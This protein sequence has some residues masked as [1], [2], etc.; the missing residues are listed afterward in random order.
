MISQ[1]DIT[2]LMPSRSQPFVF[3]CDDLISH[4]TSNIGEIETPFSYLPAWR[5]TIALEF[6]N[7]SKTSYQ[8]ELDP[9]PESGTCLTF[10]YLSQQ[11]S[12][13]KTW[14]LALNMI[15]PPLLKQAEIQ[16][17]DPAYSRAPIHREVMYTN[18][19]NSFLLPQDIAQNEN[20][21]IACK[22]SSFVPLIFSHN[23][24]RTQLSLEH[25]HPPASSALYGNRFKAQS[26]IKH[27]WMSN[28]AIGKG[29]K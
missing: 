16:F 8:G 19:I 2:E 10:N 25:T 1:N 24:D 15:N 26:I 6:D 17:F 11:D 21:V 9:L 13:I 5:A 7:A 29:F 23:L 20:V 12:S 18:S 28:L 22:E 3:L 14:L 27:N 4:Q